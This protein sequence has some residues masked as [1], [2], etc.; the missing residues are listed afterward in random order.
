M[1][2]LAAFTLQRRR[3]YELNGK[4]MFCAP[5]N[6]LLG[7]DRRYCRKTISCG[8]YSLSPLSV[9]FFHLCKDA[10]R[11][12]IILIL[13]LLLLW[14]YSPGWA[15]ASVTIRLQASRSLALSLQS[16][17][18]QVRRHVIQPSGFWSSSASCCIQLS[19][20]IL[21]DCCVLHILL[22]KQQYINPDN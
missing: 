13:L 6:A 16:H 4:V 5:S 12:Y 21:G 7:Q 22:I 11:I 18:S 2:Y 17:P 8:K 19:V 1:L 3:Y 14:R 9:N 15:L 10:V 20:H